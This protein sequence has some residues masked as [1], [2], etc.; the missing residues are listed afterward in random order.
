M[1][2]DYTSLTGPKLFELRD[3]LLERSNSAVL[4][5]R[6][7]N[8]KLLDTAYLEPSWSGDLNLMATDLESMASQLPRHTPL[9]DW[10]EARLWLWD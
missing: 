1:R 3:T 8:E 5:A 10:L 4:E 7:K 9:L 2:L 6:T